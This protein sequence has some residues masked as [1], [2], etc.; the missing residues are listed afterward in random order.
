MGDFIQFIAEVVNTLHDLFQAIVAAQGWSFTDK[1]L[2]FWLIGLLGIVCFFVV[3][4]LFRWI[5]QWSVTVLSLIY[6]LTVLLV[7]V[8]AIEI[9]QKITGRG[10]MEF[11]DAIVGL[12]GFF[13]FFAVYLAVRLLWRGGR[14][15]YRRYGRK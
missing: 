2:H 5:S 4:V 15:L 8:F 1:D 11:D 7:I 3:Q 13:A 10:H 6:T 9:Q 14:L 12:Y